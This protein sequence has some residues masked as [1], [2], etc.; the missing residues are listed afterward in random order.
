MPPEIAFLASYG[1]PPAQLMEAARIAHREGV[2][3]DRALLAHGIVE[4]RFFYRCLARHLG[5][6]FIEEPQQ[7][8]DLGATYPQ[9]IQAGLAPVETPSG[10]TWIGAPRGDSLLT[11]LRTTRQDRLRSRLAVTT[12][13]LLSRWMR[14]SAQR[15]LAADASF[16][17]LSTDADLC[18]HSGASLLQK[19]AACICVLALTLAFTVPAL[20]ALSV[21]PIAL[22][23]LFLCAVVFRLFISAAAFGFRHPKI[24]PLEDHQLPAYTIL[25]ALSKEARIVK[26]LVKMLDRIDYPRAKLEIKIIIEEDDTE[27]RH[28]LEALPLGPIYEVIV[29]P[30]GQPRTKPRALNIALP[31]ARGEYIAVFDAEDAPHPQQLRRA[32]A[33]FAAAPSTLACLQAQ[34]AIYNSNDSWLSRLFAIEYASL[35]ELQN[36]GLARF[37]LP[38][39]VSGSSNHFRTSVLR[40]VH[41]WDA[42]NVTEDA[43]IGLRLARFGYSVGVLDSV[44]HEEAPISLDTWLGQ[45]QRWFKGWLQTLM[46]ITRQ[47]MK[48]IADIGVWRTASIFLLF[49]GSVFGPLLWLPMSL[50]LAIR[51]FQYGVRLPPDGLGMCAMTLWVCVSFMGTISLFW[52]AWAGMK[53]QRLLESWPFLTLLA[54][55]YGLQTIAAWMAVY[56]LIL[57]PFRWN[58]TE[59]GLAHN[60]SQESFL[61]VL[62]LSR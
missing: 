10:F 60:A 34:L 62:R 19:L 20:S 23:L 4:E 33:C 44:T 22:G 55:Y 59:H 26:R 13:S 47:P 40:A 1:V 43:D 48:L 3:A 12:P 30:A 51:L 58:K 32:A 2:S 36:I 27:T 45:R 14:D 18:A 38:F 6:S 61:P 46:T 17:L 39:P 49:I 50:L 16:K 5:V 15:R 56:E 29:A 52:N 37:G 9:F 11:L 41:G 8:L 7:L 54:A 28:A 21:G 25:V 35:F 53:R 24:D 31:L 42:W 57:D